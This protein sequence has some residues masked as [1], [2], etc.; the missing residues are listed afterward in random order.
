MYSNDSSHE[1]GKIIF[2]D[3]QHLLISCNKSLLELIDIQVEGKKIMLASDWI[4]GIQNH[5]NLIISL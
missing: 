2:I 3:K 5:Q 4:K 1:P